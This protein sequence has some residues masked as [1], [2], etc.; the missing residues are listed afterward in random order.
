MD[1]SNLPIVTSP[2]IYIDT[3][4]DQFDEDGLM[5][6]KIFGPVRSN[7]CACNN[8]YLKS[9]EGKRC[10]KCGVLCTSN[11]IRYKTFAKI[12]LP[13]PI[14]KPSFKNKG[15]LNK[16]V[17]KHKN[18][19]DPDQ[20][21]ICQKNPV[22]LLYDVKKDYFRMTDVY[23][24]DTCLPL[25]ITGMFS[26]YIALLVL[27]DIYQSKNVEKILK[28]CFDFEL[29]VT[30]PNTRPIMQQMKGGTLSITKHELNDD[31]VE[32]I[33]LT[34]YDWT[35][36]IQDSQK[37]I[38]EYKKLVIDN[39]HRIENG[40]KVSPLKDSQLELYDFATCKY[41]K[42]V[43]NIYKIIIEAL[44]GKEGHI[45]KDLLGR[46]I[47]FS[48]RSHIIIDPSLKAY[49]IKL[50]KNNFI[51]LWFIEYMKFLIEKKQIETENILAIVK[52]TENKIIYK[53]P[54]YVDEFIDYC[55][56]EMDYHNRVVLINRQ[57][58]LF[59]YGIPAVTVVGINDH[60]SISISPLLITAM[61]AD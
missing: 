11:E 55:F 34:N 18:L 48:S 40:Q 27:L 37:T 42:Y 17:K 12:V 52:I 4:L 58:T 33:K 35:H 39:I 10:E 29:L 3:S 30:P 24:P 19:L 16:L 38:E 23:D 13:F 28:S 56:K 45:R 7:R 21:D 61:N 6:Q 44:S 43:I 9:H 14:Y 60:D 57:P 8:L 53:Y 15:L 20:I 41:Q 51:R 32:I 54:Q 31:Y 5:S 49:E 22:Y 36:V 26:T 46:S 59:R 50:P 47:D 2:K 1:K 25:S